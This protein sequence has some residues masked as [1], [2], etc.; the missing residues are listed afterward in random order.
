MIAALFEHN[1]LKLIA[2]IRDTRPSKEWFF[3]IFLQIIDFLIDV[4]LPL[5]HQQPLYPRLQ[6]FIQSL[7]HLSLA[8]Q[9]TQLI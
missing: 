2:H 6:I 5:L 4:H 7:Q 3:I 9:F 8:E 1:P